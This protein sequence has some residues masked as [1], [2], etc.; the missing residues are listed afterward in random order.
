MERFLYY[1]ERVNPFWWVLLA[2]VIFAFAKFNR[3][4]YILEELDLIKAAARTLFPAYVLLI[5]VFTVFIRLPNNE[6]TAYLIPLWSYREIVQ[7]HNMKLLFENIGNILI[8][9]PVGFLL[10]ACG[11]REKNNCGFTLFFGV[12]LTVFV[13]LFQFVTR[14]GTFE[15]DDIINNLIGVISGAVLA[16]VIGKIL[17][18]IKRR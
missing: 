16:A 8:F 14:V 4:K 1:L 18:L 11:Y 6:Y 2:A 15:T 3:N 9:V 17:R 10:P 7:T 12:C 13:E 5:F